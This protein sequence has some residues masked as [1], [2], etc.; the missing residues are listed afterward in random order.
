MLYRNRNLNL[1]A[2]NENLANSN[3]NGRIVQDARTIIIEDENIQ[4]PVSKAVLI[5]K[6][7]VGFQKS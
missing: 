7:N 6:L 3:E 4:E 5:Q 1:N 2:R